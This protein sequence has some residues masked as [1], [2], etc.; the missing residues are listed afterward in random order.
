VILGAETGAGLNI[1]Q[2]V[3]AVDDEDVSIDRFRRTTMSGH[4]EG[5][6]RFPS[7][8]SYQ[9]ANT[10]SPL[11]AEAVPLGASTPRIAGDGDGSHES[12][13]DPETPRSRPSRP[14]VSSISLTLEDE[15]P[16]ATR[17]PARSN[18]SED[19]SFGNIALHNYK[20]YSP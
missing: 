7:Y 9:S 3:I 11:L 12:F 17:P 1:A 10:D 2:V 4:Q 16:S 13:G 6:A 18:L 8:A 14:G 5:H 15:A 19:S 20:P